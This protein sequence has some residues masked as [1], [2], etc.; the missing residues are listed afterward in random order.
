MKLV[1]PKVELWDKKEDE[2]D[3][4]FIERIGRVCYK[5]E[6]R[7]TLDGQS[8]KQLVGE[9][10]VGHG[11][12]AVLEHLAYVFELDNE[13]FD[14]INSIISDLESIYGCAIYLNRTQIN[15]RNLISGNIRAWRD[16]LKYSQQHQMFVPL[17]IYKACIT[18]TTDSEVLFGDLVSDE[19]KEWLSTTECK[20]VMRKL[21]NEELFDQEK[22]YHYY[23]TVHF[24]CDRGVTHEIV[25]H[26]PASYA[27]ESTRYC[28]YSLGKFDGDCSFIDVS[29]GIELDQ[30]MSRLPEED[31][32][33]IKKMI[34]DVN[35]Y[36]ED[37][38]SNILRLGGTPQIARDVL[39]TGLKTELVMTA[40]LKEWKHFLDLR[41]EKAAHPQMREVAYQVAEKFL[42]K[43]NWSEIAGIESRKKLQNL[44]ND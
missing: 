33:R 13:M 17:Y 25:R 21:S 6:D 35:M 29:E 4:Q 27:Q 38:Y 12:E 16:F 9:M 42:E 1:Q 18:D 19:F 8:A 24:I 41:T 43:F 11:H 28:N 15:H 32:Q 30:K 31:K 40:N 26:R 14:E 3:I 20:K 34:E 44:V 39:P 22:E 7:I 36:A 10:F 5:S 23:Q 37:A 2:L